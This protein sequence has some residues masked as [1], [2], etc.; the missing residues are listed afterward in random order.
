MN[1][2]HD[3]LGRTVDISVVLLYL[4]DR[5]DVRDDRRT[6]RKN[7]Q[8]RV[9]VSSSSISSLLALLLVLTFLALHFDLQLYLGHYDDGFG[10]V[11]FLLLVFKS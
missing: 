7:G 6:N 11:G 9:L 5:L 4:V 8:S 2:I 1:R 3:V 10:V